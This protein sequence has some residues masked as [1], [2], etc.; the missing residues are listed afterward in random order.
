MKSDHFRTPHW[1]FWLF[2]ALIVIVS[3]LAQLIQGPGWKLVSQIAQNI[4]MA[5]IAVSIIDWIWRQ[6]GGDPLMNAITDLR[7]AT[8]LLSDLHGTGLQRVFISRDLT[9]EYR[10][11]LIEKMQN[12]KEVDMVGI[13][14]RSGWA[15]TTEFQEVLKARSKAD[16]T[17]FRIAVFDPSAKVTAQR[18]FEE[19]GKSTHR[20]SE[21]ASST[22]RILSTI[23]N[24]LAERDKRAM[25][26]KV[27]SKT[28]LYCS[29][30][31]VDDFMFVTKYLLHLSGS[32]SETYVIDGKDGSYFKMYMEEFNAI[33]NRSV[34]WSG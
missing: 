14:L 34:N 31:R 1:I 2:G 17:S 18:S 22:L 33:W 16:K 21:S 29:I 6:V 12:A 11:H 30:I 13:A 28:N 32:N 24:E 20:V 15:S 7:S 25:Q 3:V 23:K 19:D 8:T 26:I 4:G 9:T 10:R 27:V 5:I